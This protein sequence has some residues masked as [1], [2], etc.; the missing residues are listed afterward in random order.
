MATDA[1]GTPTSLGIPKYNTAVDPP[2]GKG[3]NA[4]MDAIDALIN[5]RVSAPGSPSTN[6]ALI[7]NGSAW[8][9]QTIA[10]ANVATNA[11][12][13]TTKIAAHDQAKAYR[14]NAQNWSTGTWTPYPFE[15]L[16][17]TAGD[18]ASMWSA[19]PNPSRMRP[20]KAGLYL[21]V[22]FTGWGANTG[23]QRY[24]SLCMN[25]GGS[26]SGQF[27]GLSMMPDTVPGNGTN[28]VITGLQ[29]FNGTTDY[30]ELWMYQDS[31]S[32]LVTSVTTAGTFLHLVQLSN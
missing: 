22:G 32:T 30:A 25:S 23:G 16:T 13:Q 11:A 29:R 9:T 8:V 27:A 3:F 18:G 4:A 24:L 15:A 12:I 1:T 26:F 6:G 20:T 19:S 10:D 2:S 17:Q 28:M 21:V 14:T 7:W 5:A 31:G